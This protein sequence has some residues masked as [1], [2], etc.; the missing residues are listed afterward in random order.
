MFLCGAMLQIGKLNEVFVFDAIRT[1]VGK[2]GGVLA[3]V[4]PDDLLAN[5]LQAL[6][7]RNLSL[8]FNLLEDVIAGD[9]NQAGEDNR[10]VARMAVLLAGLPV[11]TAGVTVNRMCGSG[12]QAVMDAARA[13]A[14]GEGELYI[15]AGV[16]SM[17][18][19][20]FIIPKA[21]AAHD[22]KM[23][24]VDSTIG[25]RF[26]NPR[27]SYDTLSMGE[28]AELVAKRFSITRDAQDEFAVKSQQKYAAAKAQNLWP[29]EIIGVPLSPNAAPTL[30]T[31]DEHPRHIS[32]DRL[33][34][35]RPAFVK[36]GCITAG[37]AAGIGDGAAGLLLGSAQLAR[38]KD[39]MVRVVSM[40]VA[41][42][43]PNYMGLGPIPA[44]GKAIKRAG[45]SVNDI[46]LFEINES[47][48]VQV[49]A[50]MNELSIDPHKV[51]VNGG[52]IAIGH[53]LGSSGARVCVTLIHE[54]QRRKVRYGLAAMCV[55]VGQG[56]AIIFEQVA[57]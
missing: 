35:L 53:P 19:A 48:A 23:E 10:N 28:T 38:H 41:G 16:E 54:M 49:I 11:S 18:R 31:E 34:A 22:R 5:V 36:D 37:N 45:L 57:R 29:Q 7:T 27:M 25:W 47:F 4:R 20:P 56:T 24:M 21:L 12:M 43:E 55:G 39:P 6:R 26:I 8:D 17:S 3:G 40:A 15:G 52:A 14:C 9:V 44:I 30:A 51:N 46:D 13:I 42:V 2:Y 33:A 50:C 1:P 32:F